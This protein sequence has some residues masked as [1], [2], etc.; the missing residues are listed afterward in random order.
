MNSVKPKIVSNKGGQS[1][2]KKENKQMMLEWRLKRVKGKEFWKKEEWR[3]ANEEK[4][5]HT[6]FGSKYVK[7]KVYCLF[8]LT[9][10]LR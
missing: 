7:N 6:V 5:K 1:F 10:S 8:E 3:E 2:N 9:P 4:K